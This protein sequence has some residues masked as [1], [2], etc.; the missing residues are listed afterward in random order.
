MF[1]GPSWKTDAA[2]EGTPKFSSAHGYGV[3]TGLVGSSWK[4]FRPLNPP[5]LGDFEDAVSPP[6]LGGGGE[7]R[8]FED[9]DDSE[10]CIHGRLTEK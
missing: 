5:I 6:N 1:Y 3:Y 4:P 8:Q 2:I 10:I 7:T 9:D